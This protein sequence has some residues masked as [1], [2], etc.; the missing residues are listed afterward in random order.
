MFYDFFKN[1]VSIFASAWT[2]N[3]NEVHFVIRN[4]SRND[5]SSFKLYPLRTFVFR[6]PDCFISHAGISERFKTKLP[7][8]L[9]ITYYQLI[10]GEETYEEEDGILW[11]R[12][13]LLNLGKLQLVGHTKQV[14]V[15][16]D[17]KSNAAYIDT[18]HV[19]EQN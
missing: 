3:G 19:Q 7:K 5:K 9:K 13:R 15:K 8:I 11:T 1:P 17:N 16:I 2:Y 12:E 10:L 4:Q 18:G 6:L 14:D